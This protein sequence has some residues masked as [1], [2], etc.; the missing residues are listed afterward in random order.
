MGEVDM[1]LIPAPLPPNIHVVLLNCLVFLFKKKYIYIY[2]FPMLYTNI[3]YNI[4]KESETSNISYYNKMVSVFFT[5]IQF[6]N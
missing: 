5:P 6:S 4:C 2:I 1:D 3:D